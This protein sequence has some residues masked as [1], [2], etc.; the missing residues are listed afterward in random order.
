M[1]HNEYRMNWIEVMNLN[2]IL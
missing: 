2:P 1:N